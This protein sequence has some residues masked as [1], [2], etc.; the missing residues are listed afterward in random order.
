MRQRKSLRVSG[1]A[2]PWS[3]RSFPHC[4]AVLIAR[5][6]PLLSAVWFGV[7]CVRRLQNAPGG[8]GFSTPYVD[9][10]AAHL[11]AA[12]FAAMV[13]QHTQPTWHSR[14]RIAG[15]ST[16][17][18]S[19][20]KQTSSPFDVGVVLIARSPS[21]CCLLRGVVC[22]H[23]AAATTAA[24]DSPSAAAAGGSEVRGT[25]EAAATATGCKR[26][27]DKEDS[28]R[29]HTRHQPG[30]GRQVGRTQSQHYHIQPYPQRERR[31]K[32]E[33]DGDWTMGSWALMRQP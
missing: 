23:R 19:R 22:C 9:T 8:S 30:R 4:A 31:W 5:C 26:A 24:A 32:R 3:F 16:R 28:G 14:H 20:T 2:L 25:A 7:V 17:Q 11:A 13:T 18:H 6:S 1:S 10:T 33:E 21:V 29:H 15:H 27:G 12:Q